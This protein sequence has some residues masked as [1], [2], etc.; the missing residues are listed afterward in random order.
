[1]SQAKTTKTTREQREERD[2]RIRALAAKGES[3]ATICRALGCSRPTA[4]RALGRVRRP[5]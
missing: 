1:M 2:K 3:I 4:G 5:G